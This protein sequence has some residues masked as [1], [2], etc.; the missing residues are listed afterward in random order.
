[1]GQ[2][3]NARQIT[4]QY[5]FINSGI[6]ETPVDTLFYNLSEQG[7]AVLP[8]SY[9]VGIGLSRSR[10]NSISAWDVLVD[11]RMTQWEEYRSFIPNGGANP[12]FEY[13][14]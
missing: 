3:L 12:S 1:M 7:K 6:V 13:V 5:T 8:S 10:A 2:E 4:S 9:G 11:Y 14:Q